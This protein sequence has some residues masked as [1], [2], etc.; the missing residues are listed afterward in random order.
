MKAIEFTHPGD[1][2]VIKLVD[3]KEPVP[4]PTDLLVRVYAAGVNRA[5][6]IQREG[7]YGERPDFGDSQIPGLELA[8]E[9]VALGKE[10]SGFSI[11]D[12][13]MGIV[14][15]GAYAEFAR[16]NYRLFMPIPRALSYVEGAAIPETFITAY[17]ALGHLGQLR[18]G[19]WALVHAAA[20]GVG[21]SAIQLAAAMGSKSVFTVSSQEA[22][23]KVLALGGTVGVNY[24]KE[25]FVEAVKRSTKN[26][27]VDVVVDFIGGIVSRA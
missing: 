15:G 18:A 27:G 1:A 8:G 24:K 13:V 10:T 12:R 22:M 2:S 25:D 26:E 19:Q 23:D 6:I 5:D 16:G 7:H 11:G 21:S 4:R 17:E 20:G 3:V 9:V 14:G